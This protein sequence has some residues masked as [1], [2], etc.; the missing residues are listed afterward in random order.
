MRERDERLL[1][2]LESMDRSRYEDGFTLRQARDYLASLDYS[3]V[4]G[5]DDLKAAFD[6]GMSQVVWELE[7]SRQALVDI[8]GLLETPLDTQA[9]EL[10]RRAEEA[11]RN[12]L[13]SSGETRMKWMDDALR[14]FL[15]AVE[16]N[17]YDYTL[18]VKIGLILW[19]EKADLE[20]A[21]LHFEEAARYA[22]PRSAKDSC[23]AL[24]HL[25]KVRRLQDKL[26][27]AYSAAAEAVRL[28]PEHARAYYDLAIYSSLTARFEECT[29]AL[30]KAILLDR[31]CWMDSI[32]NKDLVPATDHVSAMR[33]SLKG[34]QRETARERIS[35]ARQEIEA[36]RSAQAERW[37]ASAFAE[38][39][40][41][42]QRAEGLLAADTYY[43]LLDAC[44]V[45]ERAA[46][47]AR[48]AR[49][50]A[51]QTQQAKGLAEAALAQAK[52]A[53]EEA[54]QAVQQARRSLVG[55]RAT[56]QVRRARECVHSACSSCS[57]DSLEGY[58]EAAEQA[59]QGLYWATSA[60]DCARQQAAEAAEVARQNRR[61]LLGVLVVVA[62][63]LYLIGR[64]VIRSVVPRYIPQYQLQ[65]VGN[66]CM[67]MWSP[68]GR[69]LAYVKSAGNR[70]YLTVADLSG[71]QVIEAPVGSV[72]VSV[73]YAWP[74][75]GKQIGVLPISGSRA[76]YEWSPD[77][78][79]IA[80]LADADEKHGHS[81]TVRVYSWTSGR[82][83]TH[84]EGSAGSWAG[85]A[86]TE[87]EYLKVPDWLRSRLQKTRFPS[88]EQIKAAEAAEARNPDGLNVF[89]AQ[90][91]F[92]PMGGEGYLIEHLALQRSQ[93]SAGD[94]RILEED[95]YI[96]VE[97]Q[98]VRK[99]V[100]R[101]GD[102]VLSP[103]GNHLALGHEGNIYVANLTTT[104]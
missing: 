59:R 5:F 33:A 67:P 75:E 58:V 44:P 102:P 7:C 31:R 79:Q 55:D 69:S 76:R 22:T 81:A 90:A 94:R 25:A 51:E 71:R 23:F 70:V 13:T 16:R 77:G 85:E 40:A 97:D 95:G 82:L 57:Q 88:A 72:D 21:A 8:V 42:F 14:D 61:V 53:L 46:E 80:I 62:V 45:A 103:D 17:R 56:D 100:G 54:E 84:V 99:K 37:S 11:Y 24:L 41:E 68:D 92:A 4:T 27:E 89:R 64:F 104:R 50:R 35:D 65:R 15:E 86:F 96:W 91:Y 9:R 83:V 93:L 36:A 48:A 26:E 60:A 47:L 52:A 39:V 20:K 49:D 66:G 1:K 73:S 6:Y 3:V 101:G 18:H 29:R 2:T 38:A 34:E 10:R 63:A 74:P 43:S 28:Y 12:G 78:E 87:R 19:P 98:G 32:E 30:R